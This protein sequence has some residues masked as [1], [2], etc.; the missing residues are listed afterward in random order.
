ML[1][2]RWRVVMIAVAL[3][4]MLDVGRSVYARL[5][6]ARPTELWQP[7]PEVYADLAWP[8]GSDVPASAAWHPGGRLDGPGQ[9]VEIR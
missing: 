2:S 1:G 5:G 3:L 8:P 6:H 9:H 4:L 7:A